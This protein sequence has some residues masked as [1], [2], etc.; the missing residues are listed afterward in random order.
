MEVHAPRKR[1]RPP[2]CGLPEHGE[3]V[4]EQASHVSRSLTQASWGSFHIPSPNRVMKLAFTCGLR[5]RCECVEL[6][7]RGGLSAIWAFEDSAEQVPKWLVFARIAQTALVLACALAVASPR[8]PSRRAQLFTAMANMAW[9]AATTWGVVILSDNDPLKADWLVLNFISVLLIEILCIGLPAN[10]HVACILAH[11]INCALIV[12]SDGRLAESIDVDFLVAWLTVLAAAGA[13]ALNTFCVRQELYNQLEAEQAA[14]KALISMTCD[15]G[16]WMAA[17]GD[18]IVRGDDYLDTIMGARMEGTRLSERLAESDV[19]RLRRAIAGRPGSVQLLPATIRRPD[20]PPFEAD[21]FIVAA[22]AHAKNR[23]LIGLRLSQP[24]EVEAPHGTGAP[25][26]G[27]CEDAVVPVDSQCSSAGVLRH[28]SALS[29]ATSAAALAADGVSAAIRR[30]L[31]AAA[32]ASRAESSADLEGGSVA[33]YPA[34]LASCMLEPLQVQPCVRRHMV[35]RLLSATGTRHPHLAETV[36]AALD[37]C[38]NHAQGGGLVILAEEQA[39]AQVFCGGLHEEDAGGV[40]KSGPILQTSDGGYMTSRLRGVHVSDERFSKAF[41][42]FTQH[43]ETD[44][45]PSD[46]PDADARNLPKD[47]AFLLDASGFRLKCAAKLLGLPPPRSWHGVGT[48]HEAAA[49]CAWAVSGCIALVR[50]D[51]GSIHGIVRDGGVLR[52]Y[53]VLPEPPELAL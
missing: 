42:E 50:S 11:L 28:S 15:A 51:G 25:P 46:Y 19:K 52:A 12:I 4:P 38:C 24:L 2:R 40:E 6:M 37:L 5:R 8:C 1:W 35:D 9:G 47:G 13:I 43:S 36:R 26:D 34:T 18:T 10:L 27:G 3:A 7:V 23:F 32:W 14:T 49:A 44:R 45:W 22:S 17:D 39:F 41:Q 33:S 48:K 53:R 30:Q 29:L 31:Q 16:F 20:A 21:L